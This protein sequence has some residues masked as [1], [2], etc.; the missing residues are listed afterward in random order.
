[1]ILILLDATNCFMIGTSF[2]KFWWLREVSGAIKCGK[3]VR[4]KAEGRP[5]HSPI[6][7]SYLFEH[8]KFMVAN[9][10]EDAKIKEGNYF[11]TYLHGELYG[12]VLWINEFWERVIGLNRT[13]S[14]TRHV[15]DVSVLVRHEMR[16]GGMKEVMPKFMSWEENLSV[17][18]Y[19]LEMR[20]IF[21]W[22][23]ICWKT[24]E[25]SRRLRK[26]LNSLGENVI[27]GGGDLTAWEWLVYE[28]SK[29]KRSR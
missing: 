27:Q 20:R 29:S 22:R 6:S 25:V 28:F 26:S 16:Q 4:I 2:K 9:F 19:L 23:D 14:H 1:M 15:V 24:N 17:S 8:A 21:S 10:N 11:A 3:L 7:S 13:G 12:R 18:Q 5:I